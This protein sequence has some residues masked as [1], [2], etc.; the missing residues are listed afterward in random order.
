VL[1]TIT[2]GSAA[3]QNK[4][5]LDNI[6][7]TIERGWRIAVRGPNGSG[8]STLFATI[9]GELP[10]STGSR[11]TGD[12]LELGIF[13]QD[14]AQE[15]D[16]SLSAVEVVTQHVRARDPTIS[17]EKARTVLGSLGLI[18]EKGYTSTHSYSLTLTHSLTYSPRCSISWHAKW[19]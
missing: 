16:Q 1:L 2:N 10:L 6:N 17:D 7:L 3:W 5:I 19:W 9:A 18:K 12:G 15:L 14:L 11:V 13:K 8:K 4:K